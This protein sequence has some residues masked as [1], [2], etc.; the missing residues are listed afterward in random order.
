MMEN[1]IYNELSLPMIHESNKDL[2]NQ[3]TRY[4]PKINKSQLK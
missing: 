1:K 4:L 2:Q 3:S